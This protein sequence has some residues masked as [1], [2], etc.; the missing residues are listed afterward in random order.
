MSKVISVNCG[1]SSL[2]FQLIEMPSEE[3][4]SSGIVERIGLETG[5]FTIK[6]GN[7]KV[8]NELEI[9][10]HT[11][12]VHLL[13]DALVEHKI[14]AQLDEIS[15]AGHRVVQGGDKFSGSVVVDE[16]NAKIVSDLAELA[17]LHNKANLIGYY[18][19]KEALPSIGHIFVFDTAF[20]QTMT[21]ESFLYPVPYSWYTDY[22]VRRY[23]AHG[24]S[25]Q[26]VA[27]RVLEL[28]DKPTEGSRII[29][30]HLG[31]GASISAVKDGKC[32]NTSMGF[33]PLGGIMMG[34]RSGDVDPA[35]IPYMVKKLGISAQ[36]V[37][38]KL[39]KESGM[40]GVSQISSD[41]RDIEDAAHEGKQRAVET[42]ALYVNRLVNVIGGYVF[43]M[44][45]VDSIVFTA[46]VGENDGSL[47]ALTL[48]AL[49]EVL[50]LDV[51]YDLNAKSR[52]KEIQL[53]TSKSKVQAWIV[54][55]NEELMIARD[56]VKLLNV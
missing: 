43:Q 35:I 42:Q 7:Q 34:T 45:G 54:P 10:D 49:E 1:S 56:A 25:H 14:V 31:N 38:D 53:T 46:G 24:T 44:G 33:T 9:K 51:D 23:G 17:P 15:A 20:H 16:E 12:A 11:Q 8:K 4:I 40:L 47:R 28:M 55:T 6:F 52:G 36:E 50:G 2:K 26:Y 48:K 13:L 27:R 3:V 39:N 18:A 41:A 19:F 22:Q 37:I 29:T 32:V 30:C 5:I 21:A